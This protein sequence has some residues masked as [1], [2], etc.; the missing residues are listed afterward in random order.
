MSTLIPHKPTPP[1]QLQFGEYNVVDAPAHALPRALLDYWTSK[2][3]G[4]LMPKKSM[5]D[6]LEIP[7]LLPHIG[8]VDVDHSTGIR[9]KIRL[10]G[11][12]VVDVAG[13][14]RTGK[15]IEDFG[16]DL[17]EDT[18]KLLVQRWVNGCTAT[19]EQKK[20]FFAIGRRADPQRSFHIVHT[21]A[22]PL[23][24]NGTEV[25]QI[26]GLMVT[27]TDIRQN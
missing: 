27:E 3:D 10:Y 15:F 20:P 1:T 21:A 26:L 5:I 24:T 14:E 22:L 2:L 17:P 7:T 23:T 16:E 25:D 11:T 12:D 19:Y 6:P 18:R 4:Q 13:E 8:I 9:F